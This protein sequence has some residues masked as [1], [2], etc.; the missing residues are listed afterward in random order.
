MVRLMSRPVLPDL[1]IA[2][3]PKAGSTSLFHWLTDHPG[4]VGSLEKETYFLVDP[5]THMHRPDR[6]VSRGLE[7]YTQLFP[8]GANDGR[9]RIEATPSYMVH[10]TARIAMADMPSKPLALFILREPVAQIRSSFE[11]FRNNWSWI[12]ADMTFEDWISKPRDPSIFGGN[13]LAADPVGTASYVRH[14]RLW[15]EAIGAERIIIC[16]FEDMVADRRAFMKRLAERLELTPRFYETYDFP[17][18]NQTYAVRNRALQRLNIAVRGHLPRGPAYDAAR[19]V[20][21]A[22]NTTGKRK[23]PSRDIDATLRDTLAAEN[24]ALGHEFDLN[25]STWK[26][27]EP[28]H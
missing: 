9:L 12:P 28:A 17:V 5:G 27:R 10:Q 20:Y 22:V 8:Q 1:I 23:T 14:L 18:E 15:R 3:A 26:T 4:A 24:A 11:Y 25:L 6:H 16:L 7:G 2:G 21:R 19:A 13:E